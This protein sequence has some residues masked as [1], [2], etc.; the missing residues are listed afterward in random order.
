MTWP[1]QKKEEA[2]EDETEYHLVPSGVR[3]VVCGDTTYL[4]TDSRRTHSIDGPVVCGYILTEDYFVTA[5]QVV[6]PQSIIDYQVPMGWRSD[7]KGLEEAP[8]FPMP[9]EM[10]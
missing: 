5:N 9:G 10:Q 2:T 3:K 7:N 8:D 6:I 1:W 4:L